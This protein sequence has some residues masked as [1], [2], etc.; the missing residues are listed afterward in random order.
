VTRRTLLASFAAAAVDERRDVYPADR[1]R[2]ADPVTEF[3]VLRLTSPNYSSYLPPA[4]LRPVARRG[5]F[6]IY[7][8]DRGGSLQAFRMDL[9]DGTS[10]ELSRAAAMLPGSLSM[11]PDERSLCYVDRDAVKVLNIGNRRERTIHTGSGI[12]ELTRSDDGVS[13]FVV[14]RSGTTWR[15]QLLHLWKGAAA[16]VVETNEPIAAPLARPRRAG[17]LYTRNGD[18]L[19]L[20]N[21]DG[22][23][24]R[25]LKIEG[26]P[27]QA[28]WSPDGRTVLYLSATDSGVTLRECTPD[29]NA[30]QPLAKTTVFA[31][32]G[33]NADAS[34]FVGAS[35]SKA[36]PNI[37]LLLRAVKRELTLCQHRASEPAST[38]PVFS[39]DSQRIFFQSNMHGKPA[40]YS[41]AVEKLV[42]NTDEE[43]LT[44]KRPL[45][46]P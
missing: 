36:Q 37:L 31:A 2:Y 30:D 17:V 27:T 45:Q 4:H 22:Q 21:W 39:P 10:R 32:F 15:L 3:E 25:R 11:L 34:V 44:V 41:M 46:D 26:T 9:K 38:S 35:G 42:E 19:W 7:G 12:V 33:R 1:V 13:A 14:E 24:N 28:V 5:G 6:L 18:S 20:V 40:I 29:T 8:C 43:R 23:Q 16:T